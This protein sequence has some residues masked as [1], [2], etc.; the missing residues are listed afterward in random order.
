V[1][2]GRDQVRGLSVLALRAA[3]GLA[4]IAITSLPPAITVLVHSQ[5][6]ST[7]SSTSALTKA[8]ARP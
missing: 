3:D 6:P 7:R 8:K 4:V 1:G 5:A 2:Q